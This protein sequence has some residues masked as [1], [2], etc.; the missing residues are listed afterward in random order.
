MSS[1][2]S[3]TENENAGAPV[4]AST[5]IVGVTL[6]S[7]KIR[8]RSLARSS[9]EATSSWI[10]RASF[11][12]S[13][14]GVGVVMR[15]TLAT[16][17]RSRAQL[18]RR[19]PHQRGLAVAPRREDHDVLPVADVGAQ[20]G[21]LGLAVREG[22]V[23]GERAELEGIDVGHAGQRN[24]DLRNALAAYGMVVGVRSASSSYQESA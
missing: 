4:W 24:A 11:S 14:A 10:A 12:A 5:V 8:S 22:L 23:E 2:R 18:L 13:L 1:G 3:V 15:S 17:T 7:P 21:D 6:R 9:G 19:P 16:S 20:L